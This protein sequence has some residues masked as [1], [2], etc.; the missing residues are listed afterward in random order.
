MCCDLETS[1]T[2]YQTEQKACLLHIAGCQHLRSRVSSF[3]PFL[4]RPLTW[5]TNKRP[6]LVDI[7]NLW[8]FIAAQY[9]S[10][11]LAP[12]LTWQ[13]II[14]FIYGAPTK[15]QGF[16]KCFVCVIILCSCKVGIT[17][18]SLPFYVRQQRSQGVSNILKVTQP[19]FHGSPELNLAHICRNYS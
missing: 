13:L 18:T 10:Q 11:G 8:S 3:P 17:M 12:A 5:K 6:T 2:S 1:G 9:A 14:T 7:S 4:S 16:F 19:V 15:H